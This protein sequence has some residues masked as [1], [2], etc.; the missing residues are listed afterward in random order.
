MKKVF[1]FLVALIIGVGLTYTG[2]NE[3]QDSKKLVAEGKSTV[4]QVTH[5][6]TYKSSRRGSRKYKLVVAFE[7]ETKEAHKHTVQVSSSVYYA[8]GKS[9]TVQVHYLPS[10]PS[11]LQAGPKAEVRYGTLLLGL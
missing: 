9:G 3:W 7:T 2:Y 11:I 5:H 8:A 6:Y 10:N 1:G 4:A